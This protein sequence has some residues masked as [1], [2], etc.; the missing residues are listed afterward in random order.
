MGYSDN[1]VWDARTHND[2]LAAEDETHR[3]AR[4]HAEAY[5][6]GGDPGVT[7]EAFA[8][9]IQGHQHQERRA[10]LADSSGL[11]FGPASD[12]ELLRMLLNGSSDQQLAA[13]ARELR[14][15]YIAAEYTQT[16]IARVAETLMHEV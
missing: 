15:R 4:R 5:A 2:R 11:I 14:A 1:A 12:A 16:E 8:E 7:Q 6:T 9:F 13:V 10:L 3:A